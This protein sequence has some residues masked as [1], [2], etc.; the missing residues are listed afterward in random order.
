MAGT[1]G[2]AR[3]RV[4]LA[5]TYDLLGEVGYDGLTIDAVAARARASKATIY[6]RWQDKAALVT[7]ALEARSQHQ[8]DAVLDSGDLRQDLRELLGLFVHLAEYESLR[9][10]VSVLLAATREPSLLAGLQDVALVRRRQDCRTAMERAASRK[11]PTMSGDLLF[12]LLLGKILTRY[13]V[14]RS[15][16]TAA[17]QLEFIDHV[18]VPLTRAGDD[19]RG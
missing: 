4:I 14:E 1:R 13:L 15:P 3:E 9:A 17:D 2:Q 11:E 5:V 12:E 6:A 7:A 18:L 10:F 19:G 16:L 8:P